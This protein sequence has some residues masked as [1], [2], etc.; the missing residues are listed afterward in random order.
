MFD[1]ILGKYLIFILFFR[2][3]FSLMMVLFKNQSE[4]L[5]SFSTYPE[6]LLTNLMSGDYVYDNAHNIVEL[7]SSGDREFIH[8]SLLK[9][10]SSFLADLVVSTA[11]C[12]N[13]VIILPS[14]P[15]STLSDFVR[16]L[17][18]GQVSGVGLV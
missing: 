15:P 9:N 14:S 13:C 12:D 5:R 7:V 8:K 3:Y 4:F 1:T 2:I 17:Y 18:T 16:L 11:T 6:S 10:V